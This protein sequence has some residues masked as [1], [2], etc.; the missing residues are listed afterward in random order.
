MM[1]LTLVLSGH[2]LRPGSADMRPFWRGFI[3]LQRCLPPDVSIE[4]TVCHSWNPEL[5]ELAQI[6][7]GPTRS[8]HERQHGFAGD[9]VGR[10]D[11]PDKF[12]RGLDRANSTWKNV[13][14]ESVL[15]NSRSRSRAAGLLDGLSMGESVLL[16]RW[17]L[18]QT[19]SQD[20]HRIVLDSSLP[21]EYVYM[22]YY[23]EVDEGYADMWIVAPPEVATTFSTFDA[24]VLDSLAGNN[25]YNSLFTE[26]G[27]PSSMQKRRR[28]AWISSPHGQRLRKLAVRWQNRL[29]K[30]RR[31]A[32]F[33]VRKL[34]ALVRLCIRA[35]VAPPV[36][37]ENSC[38]TNKGRKGPRTFP[39]YLALNIHALLKYFILSHGLRDRVRFISTT[40]FSTP[41]GT[42]NAVNP[43]PTVLLVWDSNH[44]ETTDGIV[45]SELPVPSPL[46]VTMS[47]QKIAWSTESP[48]APTQSITVT[49]QIEALRAAIDL[50]ERHSLQNFPILILPTSDALNAVNDPP[51]LNALLKFSRWRRSD[52]IGL[53]GVGSGTDS[54]EFP[55][56]VVSRDPGAFSLRECIV[57]YENLN[58]ILANSESDID[59]LERKMGSMRLAFFVAKR[60]MGSP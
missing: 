30:R 46:V 60:S 16:T 47:N 33:L 6:V 31:S 49:S 41:E 9:F 36:T 27:W 2:I 37:A 40:D 45:T 53:H 42:G 15:G 34:T 10:I 14:L 54:P 52:Y 28:N 5:D 4:Q 13:S 38:L 57:S 1:Q 19:G 35:I 56:M 26:S 25:S 51:Y 39:Q 24:S 18:G 20:V 22:A 11:P 8:I 32:G 48:A 58:V 50:V 3:E 12:E 55:E 7:Y 43:E 44:S 29:E 17:D 59:S 23:N 21:R